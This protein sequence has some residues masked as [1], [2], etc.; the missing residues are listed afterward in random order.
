M[1]RNKEVD[2]TNDVFQVEQNTDYFSISCTLHSDCQYSISD[3]QGQILLKGS[4]TKHTTVAL[5]SLS[6][7]YYNLILFNALNRKLIPFR[8]T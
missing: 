1:N 3:T 8:I 6:A 4:F 2:L 7:G 5:L